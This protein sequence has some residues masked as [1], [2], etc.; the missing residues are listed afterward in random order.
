MP[1]DPD[2]DLAAPVREFRD[3]LAPRVDELRAAGLDIDAFLADCDRFLAWLEGGEWFDA[4]MMM[5]HLAAFREEV[6]AYN[7]IQFQADRIAAEAG[8]PSMLDCTARLADTLR[9][10]TG[11]SERRTAADLDAAVAEARARLARGESPVEPL[12]DISLVT[13]A[14]AAELARR[15]RF[16]TVAT[17]LYWERQPPEWW[18]QR[19]PEERAAIEPLLAQ[20]RTE[21]EELLS[22]LPLEDR[23]RLESLRLEDFQNPDALRP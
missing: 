13:Q 23:R 11:D 3:H 6:A 4:S 10:H 8:I 14:H 21:R 9:R 19:T 7:A 12:E 1:A 22:E 5:D 16:R 15:N 17:A 20:W 2:D 18:A